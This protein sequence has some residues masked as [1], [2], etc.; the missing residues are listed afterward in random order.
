MSQQPQVR[1]ETNWRRGK[2]SPDV[3]QSGEATSSAA[4]AAN[5]NR[6]SSHGFN[7]EAKDALGLTVEYYVPIEQEQEALEALQ[8]AGLRVKSVSPRRSLRKK[9]AR[10]PSRQEMIQL[11]EQLGDQWEAAEPPTQILTSLSKTTQNPLLATA[12]L[13]AAEDVRNGATV[14]EALKNQTT[15]T[16]MPNPE[17]RAVAI[18]A[19]KKGRPVFPDLFC[20]AVHNAEEAGAVE[21]PLTGKSQGAMLLMM[22]RYALDQTRIGALWASL[23]GAM[24]Y[25]AAVIVAIIILTPIM[26]YYALPPIKDMFV[27]MTGGDGNDLPLPTRILI[28]VSDFAMTPTGVILCMLLLLCA[29]APFVWYRTPKG[30][31]YILRKSLWMP[32]FGELIRETNMATLARTLGMMASGS[33]DIVFALRESARAMNNPT[34]RDMLNSILKEYLLDARSLDI[35]FRPYTPLVTTDFNAILVS[36]ERS[37]GLDKLCARLASVLERRCERRIEVIKH[38]LNTYLIFPLAGAALFFLLAFYGPMISLIG[39]MSQGH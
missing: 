15:V 16:A 10:I 14:S 34:Y 29:V 2:T 3:A 17:K 6:T 11:A 33:G 25:P 39:K 27:A 38:T 26:L 21:D 7:F 18:K 36:Y 13:N 5:A 19:G 1:V 23:R 31:D 35:L 8:R 37:G 24:M 30:K 32:L 22:E 9:Q 4:P 20:Y 28:A 12:L